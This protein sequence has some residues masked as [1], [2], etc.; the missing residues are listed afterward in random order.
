MST[1]MEAG[2]E[3]TP[4]EVLVIDVAEKVMGWTLSEHETGGTLNR[5]SYPVWR[6][7]QGN[8]VAYISEW[9]PLADL[10]D[11]WRVV[12][13]VHASDPNRLLMLSRSVYGGWNASFLFGG[14]DGVRADT[15]PL[16]ISLAA[17][18]ALSTED[19]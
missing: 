3:R 10:A 12:E 1:E 14:A 4:E 15:A 8:I 19:R 9:A 7:S 6:D 2:R 11:A 5:R 17:L 18:A 16:A 13:A